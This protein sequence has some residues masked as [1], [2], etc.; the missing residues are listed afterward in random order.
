MCLDDLDVEF[1]RGLLF[2]LLFGFGYGW[3]DCG[4]LFCWF[5]GCVV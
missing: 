4:E 3:I 1:L 2:W 5:V